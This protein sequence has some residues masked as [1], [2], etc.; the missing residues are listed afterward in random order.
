MGTPLFSLCVDPLIVPTSSD[1]STTSKE[2]AYCGG[3]HALK[4]AISAD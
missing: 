3:L 2:A 1:G 4:K